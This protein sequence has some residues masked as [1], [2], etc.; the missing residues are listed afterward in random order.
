M[1]KETQTKEISEKT[2]DEI[3]EVSIV[4]TNVSNKNNVNFKEEERVPMSRL[5]KAI[6]KRL[7]DAQNNAAM[8]TTYNE[9]DMTE[10]MKIRTNF[11]PMFEKKHSVKLGFMS[12]L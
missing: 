5:R 11:Q 9:V 4:N 7:K 1:K 6:A 8:L 12:F 3:K 2:P 10:V